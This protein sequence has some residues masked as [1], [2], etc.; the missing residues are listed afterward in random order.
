[1]ISPAGKDHLR[2]NLGPRGCVQLYVRTDVQ[3]LEDD[4]C[5][6]GKQVNRGDKVYTP[7]LCSL[8]YS[9]PRIF[10][11]SQA[12]ERCGVKSRRPDWIRIHIDAPGSGKTEE[13]RPD[14][15]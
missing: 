2:D 8:R 13:S 1:M 10:G 3:V 7:G 4:V 11:L 15:S 14:V 6:K 12:R 5:I 9:R